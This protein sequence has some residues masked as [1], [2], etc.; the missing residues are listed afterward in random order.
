MIPETP[1]QDIRLDDEKDCHRDLFRSHYCLSVGA[2]N[3][4]DHSGD[5]EGR[6]DLVLG[7]EGPFLLRAPSR[8]HACVGQMLSLLSLDAYHL[9][10]FD[11]HKSLEVAYT[12]ISLSYGP[13]DFL[14]SR[15]EEADSDRNVPTS[16]LLAF[17]LIICL[18]KKSGAV[19]LNVRVILGTI[20]EDSVWYF[21]VIFTSQLV[22]VLTLEFARVSPHRFSL[23]VPVNDIHC[24]SL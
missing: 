6:Y 7:S 15:P 20:V 9:C 12:V 3:V 5:K 1:E 21:L 2:W 18:A 8:D 23:L 16:D 22:L 10:V 13:L 17:S 4:A 24:P 11:Q 14:E 19:S